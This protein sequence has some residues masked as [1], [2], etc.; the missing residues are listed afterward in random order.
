MRMY[1]TYAKQAPLPRA[2]LSPT[3]VPSQRGD[4]N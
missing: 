1:P 3:L 4:N 2:A